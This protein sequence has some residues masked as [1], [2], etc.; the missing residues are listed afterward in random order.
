MPHLVAFQ[1]LPVT[2]LGE[3]TESA[4][5]LASHVTHNPSHLSF[6]PFLQGSMALF[7]ILFGHSMQWLDVG[8]Q[9]RDQG[10]NPGG[11]SEST[12]T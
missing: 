6:L 2:H 7:N 8:S 10:L 4:L 11:N 3:P 1:E 5:V 12:N 9:C